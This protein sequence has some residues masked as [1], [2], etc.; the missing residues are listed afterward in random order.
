MKVIIKQE[1]KELCG[2]LLPSSSGEKLHCP[3][4]KPCI[5]HKP[6]KIETIYVENIKI[7]DAIQTVALKLNELIRDYNKTSQL[8]AGCK[9]TLI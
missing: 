8:C 5:R 1:K 9:R 4:I 3:T 7:P 6:Q 2:E